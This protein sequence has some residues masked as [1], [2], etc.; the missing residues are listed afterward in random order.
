LLD[1]GRIRIRTINSDPDP[2]GPRS[3]SGFGTLDGITEGNPPVQA[4]FL[5]LPTTGCYEGIKYYTYVITT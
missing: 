1:D 4:F 3:G 2:G 5:T